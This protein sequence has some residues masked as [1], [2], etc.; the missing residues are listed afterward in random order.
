MVKLNILNVLSLALLIGSHLVSSSSHAAEGL[1]R[2]CPSPER[3]EGILNGIKNTF[4]VNA[5]GKSEEDFAI[6]DPTLYCAYDAYTVEFALLPPPAPDDDD[7][8][9]SSS[10]E[11][12]L[13]VRVFTGGSFPNAVNKRTV[14]TENE[15]GYDC[16]MVRRIALNSALD[17]C[18]IAGN[19]KC[20]IQSVGLIA[21]EMIK[22]NWISSKRRYGFRAI[23]KAN[24]ADLVSFGQV[25]NG[26]CP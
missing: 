17:S 23:V 13:L 7:H 2:F 26:A 5:Y 25:I 16:Q 1:P 18:R 4:Y 21:D 19:E 24:T 10:K 15:F 20:G 14:F 11:G 22:L 3:I 8:S 12:F 6:L 9:R